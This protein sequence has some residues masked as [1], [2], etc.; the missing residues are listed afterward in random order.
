MSHSQC[1]GIV[2]TVIPCDLAPRNPGQP[3]SIRG[4]CAFCGE[5][6]C[7]T[8]CRCGRRGTA[9][10]QNRARPN[11]LA[12]AVAKAKA[13]AKAKAG[14]VPPPAHVPGPVGHPPSLAVDVLPPAEWYS[15]MLTCV[16]TAYLVVI[17]SYQYDHGPLTDLLLRRLSRPD[18]FELV[19][20]VDRE[21][22]G[23]RT[24]H[25]Q[26][27]RLEL[28]RRAGATIV[29]CRGTA[30]TGAFHAKALVADRRTA[31]VGSAN[32]TGKSAR[33]GELCFRM[34]GPPVAEIMQFLEIEKANGERL[35]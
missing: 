23:Q 14:P 2:H 13:K 4:P 21:C 6:R 26:R 18:A 32:L 15:Q 30:S 19:L 20:L 22:Y 31:F 25:L 35:T 28:L 29:L 34:R 24:P 12:K 11:P 8:H 7:R 10:G 3:V 33:N 17:G 5:R 9:T 27:P 16:M 1:R